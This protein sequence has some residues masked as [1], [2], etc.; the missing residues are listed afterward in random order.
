MGD[1][2]L[3]RREIGS[4]WSHVGQSLPTPRPRQKLPPIPPTSYKEWSILCFHDP[5]YPAT[6]KKEWQEWHQ[7]E[8]TPQADEPDEEESDE[9]YDARLRGN[10]DIFRGPWPSLQFCSRTN[11]SFFARELIRI[12]PVTG[13]KDYLCIVC[14]KAGMGKR[15]WHYLRKGKPLGYFEQAVLTAIAAVA[16]QRTRLGLN[17]P[18]IMNVLEYAERKFVIKGF[19]YSNVRDAVNLYEKRNIIR[20]VNDLVTWSRRIIML[21]TPPAPRVVQEPHEEMMC[22]DDTP[23]P[24]RVA[25]FDFK[26]C[27]PSPAVPFDAT[28]FGWITGELK[29][30]NVGIIFERINFSPIEYH[31]IFYQKDAKSKRV[32]LLSV[33]NNSD[34]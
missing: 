33:R 11:R 18:S 30:E 16:R 10:P 7:K 3:F 8:D 9:Y 20:T 13:K 21:V 22:W 12:D 4:G 14:A 15:S 32:L 17:P 23:Q 6:T 5:N 34:V 27:N 25:S 28:H 1:Q 24:W 19:N 31:Q 26:N 29:V 2:G